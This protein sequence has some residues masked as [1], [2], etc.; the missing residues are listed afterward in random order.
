MGIWIST[1]YFLLLSFF[2]SFFFSSSPFMC[3]FLP[4]LI[5]QY[6][7]EMCKFLHLIFIFLPQCFGI[8]QCFAKEYAV[9]LT[10]V[11][12]I[13]LK[14]LLDYFSFESPKI[15][16]WNISIL[17]IVEKYNVYISGHFTSQK[18]DLKSASPVF[19]KLLVNVHFWGFLP[20]NSLPH[21]ATRWYASLY[22]R[23]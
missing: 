21:L 1:S 3:I 16:I 19:E 10:Y 15:G 11:A 7:I 4:L 12:I 17:M 6:I 8:W 23:E 22:S 18:I 2:G 5:R 9:S 20:T 13:I 14:G